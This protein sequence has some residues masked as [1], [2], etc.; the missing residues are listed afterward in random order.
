M[1]LQNNPTLSDHVDWKWYSSV[2]CIPPGSLFFRCVIWCVCDVFVM[3]YLM[4]IKCLFSHPLMGALGYSWG[5]SWKTGE[6][7]G[8]R[9]F[10]KS[11]K[12]QTGC[13]LSKTWDCDFEVWKAQHHCVQHSP[14]LAAAIFK[15]FC[16]LL[17]TNNC[18]LINTLETGNCKSELC[19]KSVLF[20]AC[21]FKLGKTNTNHSWA[22]V[23][24][25]GPAGIDCQKFLTPVQPFCEVAANMC[26]YRCSKYEQY[27]WCLKYV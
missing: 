15:V 27:R 12:K 23:G 3:C 21:G 18:Y 22:N 5:S 6:G 1:N 13:E 17:P 10:T 14:H 4:H 7:E 8:L 24:G 9:C 11:W 19:I 26:E 2:T 16:T 20:E 25:S